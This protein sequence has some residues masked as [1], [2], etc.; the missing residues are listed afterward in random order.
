MRFQLRSLKY[1][2]TDK[3]VPAGF[4]GF[5]LEVFG[6]LVYGSFPRSGAIGGYVALFSAG[7]T[8][9]KQLSQGGNLNQPW[10]FASAP[11]P[12]TPS[13][14]HASESCVTAIKK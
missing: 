1:V 2:L 3:S 11:S 14:A 7:G 4:S 12:T 6:G 13:P 5:D 8:L 10:G 9:L